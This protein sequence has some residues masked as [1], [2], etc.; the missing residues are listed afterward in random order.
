MKKITVFLAVLIMSLALMPEI[1]CAQDAENVRLLG[2]WGYGPVRAVAV[3]GNTVYLGARD[4]VF[5]VDVTNPSS[6]LKVGEFAASEMIT[7]TLFF[8]SKYGCTL[9]R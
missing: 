9:E 6:P 4:V 1:C 2:R 3:K 5:V 7:N 8:L